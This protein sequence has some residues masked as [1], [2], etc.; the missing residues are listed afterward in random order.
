M[1]KPSCA[2]V[3]R[4]VKWLSRY[5]YVLIVFAGHGYH[6]TAT[7]STFLT[8]RKGEE[9]DSTRLRLFT[10]QTIILDCCRVERPTLPVKEM[11]T[12]IAKAAPSV[13]AENCRRLY[14]K[15]IESASM[16]RVTMYACAIG[17]E[18]GDA[19]MTIMGKRVFLQ[20]DNMV[21]FRYEILQKTPWQAPHSW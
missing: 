14:D 1:L 11:V 6:S 4:K 16:D 19:A 7:K 15:H 13:N 5:D 9:L 21:A 12:L 20:M 2:D 18:A 10:R 8:L 17:E 3:E